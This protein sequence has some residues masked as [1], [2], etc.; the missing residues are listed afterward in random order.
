MQNR[1]DRLESLVLSLM[2]N[3]SQAAGPAAAATAILGSRTAGSLDDSQVLEDDDMNEEQRDEDS[4]VEQVS[5]SIGIM[6]VQNDRQFY[7]SEAHWY[8]I[9]SDVGFLDT[10]HLGS[11]TDSVLR[12][13]LPKSRATSRNTRSSMTSK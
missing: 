1:I 8:A 4:D 13:R 11:F 3:G 9:L 10:R 7:A 5:R 12:F 2:T 6:K